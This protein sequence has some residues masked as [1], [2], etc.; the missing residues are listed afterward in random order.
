MEDEEGK[1]GGGGGGDG[2]GKGGEGVG[3]IS[4]SR[5]FFINWR[6]RS[7]ASGEVTEN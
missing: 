6:R 1:K 7:F 3:E 5:L 2:K 4:A